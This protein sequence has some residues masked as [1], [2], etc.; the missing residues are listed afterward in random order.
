MSRLP[1][2]LTLAVATIAAAPSAHAVLRLGNRP[3]SFTVKDTNDRDFQ[4][5]ALTGGAPALIVYVD[6][7]G[8]EQNKHV[9]QRL[10]SLKQSEPQLGKVRVIPIVD[11]SDYNSWPKRG[12]AKS[13]L[14]DESKSL[15][16]TVFADWDGSG[17]SRLGARSG[18]SNLILLD[19][20]GQVVWASAGELVPSQEDDL[21]KG[22]HEVVR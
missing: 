16:Y 9:R 22:L 21:I 12:F 3:A 6:K 4:L 1:L 19:K 5:G 14:R 17:K 2:A 7:N 20:K 15:G 10:Q 18:A 13:A 8:A 11:V